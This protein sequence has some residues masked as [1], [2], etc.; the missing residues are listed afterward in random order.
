MWMTMCVSNNLVLHLTHIPNMM[1]PAGRLKSVPK[2][3]THPKAKHTKEIHTFSIKTNPKRSILLKV[4]LTVTP[5]RFSIK[6]DNFSMWTIHKFPTPPGPS[7]DLRNK[8]VD[9]ISHMTMM[10]T[11]P[12]SIIKMDADTMTTI[13]AMSLTI[14]MIA[15]GR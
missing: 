3:T 10:V 6:N 7:V 15:K 1:L 9:V 13:A 11:V 4:K 12:F 8:M 14:N 2:R 5:N